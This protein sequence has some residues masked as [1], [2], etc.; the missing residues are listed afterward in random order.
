MIVGVINFLGG[1]FAS[2]DIERTGGNGAPID[3]IPLPPTF[4]NFPSVLIRFRRVFLFFYFIICLN[5][6]MSPPFSLSDS[7]STSAPFIH[8]V[9]FCLL[10]CFLSMSLVA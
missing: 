10:V 3:S 5:V 9:V 6:V 2:F 4:T 7:L 1:Y 8:Y